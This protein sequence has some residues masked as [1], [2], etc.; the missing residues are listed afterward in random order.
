MSKK[1]IVAG[2]GHGCVEHGPNGS[3]WAFYTIACPYLHRYERRIGMDLVAVDENGELYCP[4]GV[5]DTPQFIPGYLEDPI[6]SRNDA[7]CVSLTGG[8]RPVASSCLEGRDAVYATDENN[9]SFWL[10]EEE[11]IQKSLECDLTGEFEVSA[12]RIFWRELGLDYARGIVPAPVQYIVE[13]YRGGEWF[14]LLDMS[15][16]DIEKNI[17]YQVFETKS[18]SKVRL[19]IVGHGK[20]LRIG[21]IDFSVFGKM[22]EKNK[23]DFTKK[24]YTDGE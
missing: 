4:H 9:L 1:I 5:T 18:C 11:D 15:E 20:G 13:G 21:V 10:P 6:H 12:C 3:L 7:G 8:C 24:G 16:N 22:A 19:K 17:D 23:N 2:A 14:L